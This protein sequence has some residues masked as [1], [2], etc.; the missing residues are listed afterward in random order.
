MEYKPEKIEKKWQSSWKKSGIYKTKDFVKDKD[1]FYTLVMFPYPS[2]DLHIGHWYNF[3]PADI[4]ARFK[5]LQGYNTLLPLGF[6]AFGLPAENAAINRGLDPEKWTLGNIK[7]MKK[8]LESMGAMYDWDRQVVTCDPEYYKWTQWLFIK[9]YEAGLAYR[10]KI[11]VNWC[12]QCKTVLANEQNVDGKCWRCNTEVELKNVEQW[13]LRI[14]KYSDRLL[15]D[16]EKIN[17]P[18]TTKLAQKNWIGKSEGTLIKFNIEKDKT[19]INES[20]EVFTTRVDTLFGVTYVVLA[21]EHKLINQLK[22]KIENYKEIGVYVNNAKKKTELD[23]MSEAKEK[24]G[25]KLQGIKAVN[26]INNEGVDVWIADYVL[27]SYGTGAVMAVPAHDQ[28]DFDFAKKYSLPIKEVISSSESGQESLI[29][30]KAYEE[31]GWLINSRDFN[32]LKSDK[33]RIAITTWLK[34]KQMGDSKTNYRM[35]DWIVSRQRYWGAPIPM[36]YCDKCSWQPVK[37]EELPIKLPK[38]KDFK[39]TGEMKSP[40]AKAEKWVSAK[41]PKCNGPAKRETDTLD[42]FVDSSWYLFRYSDPKNKKVFAD[43]KK[44]KAWLPINMY[45]GGAEH[46]TK[47]LLYIRFVTKALHDLGYFDFEEPVSVLKHQGLILGPDGQKMSKSLGNVVNPDDYIKKYGSDTFRMYLC[48]MGPYEQGGPW[49]PKGILGIYRFLNRVNVLVNLFN[50]SKT[51]GQDN[52]KLEVSLNKAI[53]KITEDLEDLR[54]NTAVSELMKLLNDFEENRQ[55]L[56]QRHIRQFLILLSPFAPHISEELFHALE[57]KKTSIFEQE[58]PRYDTK[59]IGDD[60]IEMVIQISGKTRGV[61]RVQSGLNQKQVEDIVLQDEKIK[62]YIQGKPER[63]IFV[64]NRLI[65]FVF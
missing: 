61:I 43:S 36:I 65:N 55:D 54:F 44:I 22:D 49:Q 29:L 24:S 38:L 20:L 16:L 17:W 64:K 1:N 28:R 23:R 2:G 60:E 33:A 26:P 3:A 5:K 46:A 8:Q 30:E 62:K 14:T 31:D 52:K 40:L 41:C 18:E 48:F 15:S 42:T 51:D 27:G 45:I 25:V 37:E 39:P 59:L 32:E 7:K 47:H 6:D 10:D 57:D 9:L 35:H 21:P 53:K 56:T 11:I 34:Q 12:P 4:F 50:K 13:L 58:W 63:T 19:K